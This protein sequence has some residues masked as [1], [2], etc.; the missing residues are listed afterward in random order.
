MVKA[1]RS[2]GV[3]IVRVEVTTDGKISIIT[4]ESQP[5]AEDGLDR[6]LTAFQARNGQG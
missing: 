1:V 2:A 4:S 6:E 5:A 3:D